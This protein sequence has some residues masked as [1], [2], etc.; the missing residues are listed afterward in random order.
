MLLGF[1]LTLSTNSK[2]PQPL[3][4]WSCDQKG[5]LRFKCSLHH[6]QAQS[7]FKYFL[8]SQPPIYPRTYIRTVTPSLTLKCKTFI[9]DK[10]VC[11]IICFFLF[12]VKDCLVT[13]LTSSSFHYTFHLLLWF[14]FH[15]NLIWVIAFKWLHCIEFTVLATLFREHIKIYTRIRVG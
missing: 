10:V 4:Y 2:I 11:L 1:S 8:K 9:K 14:K 15:P 3:Y 13:S 5:H 6:S 12:L 7:T